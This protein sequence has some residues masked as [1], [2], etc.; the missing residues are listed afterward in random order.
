MC[1]L[2]YT[3]RLPALV[4]TLFAEGFLIRPDVEAVRGE[5]M[6]LQDVSRGEMGGGS[7]TVE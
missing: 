1:E 5:E 7:S 4:S 2:G 3:N 6:R